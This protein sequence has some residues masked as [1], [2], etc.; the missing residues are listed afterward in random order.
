MS[1]KTENF[2]PHDICVG[3]E[4]EQVIFGGKLPCRLAPH[5]TTNWKF[6]LIGSYLWVLL[7][8]WERI[9]FWLET[10]YA[11][12]KSCFWREV[13]L[14]NKDYYFSQAALAEM[15]V[16]MQ[17][18]HRNSHDDIT[19]IKLNKSHGAQREKR[20]YDVGSSEEEINFSDL[21][22]WIFHARRVSF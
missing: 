16:L 19:G 15:N 21:H 7:L 2:I 1:W 6:S 4:V 17:K 11:A 22:S 20:S 10:S 3:Y 14:R 9:Y 12:A 5:E 8:W 13:R 18:H